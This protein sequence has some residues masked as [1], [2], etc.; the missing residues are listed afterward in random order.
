MGGVLSIIWRNT[1]NNLPRS[2]CMMSEFISVNDQN[3]SMIA[4]LLI[5]GKSKIIAFPGSAS[6]VGVVSGIEHTRA[7][8]YSVHMGFFYVRTL[9]D[10]SICPMLPLLVAILRCLV[11]FCPSP[12]LVPS[13]FNTWPEPSLLDKQALFSFCMR[14]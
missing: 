11:I 7:R 9:A 1:G 5:W 4:D 10:S 8:L 6:S 13:L 12:L 14:S 2:M 3:Q